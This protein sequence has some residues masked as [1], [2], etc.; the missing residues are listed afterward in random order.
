MLIVWVELANVVNGVLP[1]E[2]K[3]IG[4]DLQGGLLDLSQQRVGVFD[5]LD[6]LSIFM[7]L[8]EQDLDP[9]ERLIVQSD[10]V[11]PLLGLAVDIAD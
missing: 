6:D 8:F 1:Q 10:D 11:A 3:V 5:R 4:D 7:V 9:A 2:L